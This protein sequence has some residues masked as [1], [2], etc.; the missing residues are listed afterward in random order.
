M[1]VDTLPPSISGDDLSASSMS[2][3]CR[4]GSVQPSPIPH[5]LINQSLNIDGGH[6]A[7]TNQMPFANLNSNIAMDQDFVSEAEVSGFYSDAARNHG[8]V[9]WTLPGIPS[10]ISED[11]GVCVTGTGTPASEAEMPYA[12]SYS[13]SAHSYGVHDQA[14]WNSDR[15]APSTNNTISREEIKSSIPA[16]NTASKR[17]KLNIFMGYRADCEKCRQKVPGH[18]SHIIHA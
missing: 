4:H 6:P 3:Q 17:K 15:Q 11:E 5:S 12:T 2:T 14:L 18:Y 13:A 16:A 1:D 9:W 10:P 7:D 8:S